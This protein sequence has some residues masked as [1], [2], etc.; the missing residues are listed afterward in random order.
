M[1]VPEGLLKEGSGMFV[2]KPVGTVTGVLNVPGDKSI[3]HRALLLS[4]VAVGNSSIR[5]F[6]N[7]DDCLA[8]LAALRATGVEINSKGSDVHV[9]GVGPRGLR[10]RHRWISGTPALQFDC[11]PEC[12]PH[13][14]SIQF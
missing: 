4:A 7:S 10:A 6:L 12:S 11:W 8:T 1:T 9:C 13:N 2:S 3:S 14:R 5:G